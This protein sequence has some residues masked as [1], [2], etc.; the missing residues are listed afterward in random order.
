MP[1]S[2]H[3]AG[4]P[5]FFEYVWEK[6]SY[7]SPYTCYVSTKD[8]SNGLSRINHKYTVKIVDK[9][10]FIKYIVTNISLMYSLELTL[11]K[12]HK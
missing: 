5:Y 12:V 2:G 7:F 9:C 11:S 3:H 10:N 6:V 4:L 1:S 8:D